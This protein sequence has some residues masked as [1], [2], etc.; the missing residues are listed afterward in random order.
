MLFSVLLKTLPSPDET[1]GGSSIGGYYHSGLPSCGGVRRNKE[2]RWESRVLSC[3]VLFMNNSRC[4]SLS[5][6][7]SENPETPSVVCFTLPRRGTSLR[8]RLESS[9]CSEDL[10]VSGSK[11]SKVGTITRP[12][13]T[14]SNKTI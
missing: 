4:L 5:S 12:D 8:F 3:P 11:G 2:E 7:L 13:P 9:R 6:I 14:S 1:P 10:H